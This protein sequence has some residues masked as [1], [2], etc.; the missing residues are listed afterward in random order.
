VRRCCRG[1]RGNRGG[2]DA[3][4]GIVKEEMLQKK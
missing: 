2:G 4:E 1:K 3:A